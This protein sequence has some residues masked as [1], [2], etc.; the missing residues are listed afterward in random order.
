[1]KPSTEK[2]VPPVKDDYNTCVSNNSLGSN[3]SSLV[4]HNATGSC[5]TENK[6]SPPPLTSPVYTT[7]TLQHKNS[8]LSPTRPINVTLSTINP[9]EHDSAMK[10]ALP[11]NKC[12]HL[13]DLTHSLETD[14]K[15]VRTQNNSLREE[16][17]YL[18]QRVGPIGFVRYQSSERWNVC[19]VPQI[20]Y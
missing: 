5:E 12:I 16:R 7:P 3:Q 4:E 10:L 20:Y 17:D 18:K 15:P 2:M 14:L 19:F 8:P 11:Q 1:M 9:S 13:R 6:L